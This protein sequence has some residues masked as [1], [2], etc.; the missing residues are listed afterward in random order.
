MSPA[1]AEWQAAYAAHG[2]ATFPVGE[3]KRPAI[4]NYGLKG[5]AQ[6]ALRHPSAAGVGFMT[7]ARNRITI[8]D[9]DTTDERVFADALARHGETPVKVRTASGKWHAYYRHNGERR[10]IR[11]PGERAVPQFRTKKSPAVRRGCWLH[12]L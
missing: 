3:N 11:R 10:R 6:L 1:F 8:L 7:S 9:I 2:I 4:T 5:S 12:A